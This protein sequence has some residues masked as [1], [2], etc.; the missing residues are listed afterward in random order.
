MLDRQL[1]SKGIAEI[2]FAAG[3]TT[4]IHK[5]IMLYGMMGLGFATN[6]K[7]SFAYVE[8]HVGA[9]INVVGNGKAIAE[10]RASYGQFSSSHIK[11][12]LSLTYALYGIDNSTLSLKAKTT[13]LNN[14]RHN[15]LSLGWAYHF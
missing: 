10:Y 4:R 9:I 1:D 5:D 3:K 2:A 8:P 15:Q 11:Q 13:T 7:D 12:S 14:L 6:L